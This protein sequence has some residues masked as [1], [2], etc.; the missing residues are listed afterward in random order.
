MLSSF[1]AKHFTTDR[2]FF[3]IRETGFASAA[4]VFPSFSAFHSCR[5]TFWQAEHQGAVAWLF[6]S[7]C[8]QWRKC[9]QGETYRWTIVDDALGF[10][11]QKP[12]SKMNMW[13]PQLIQKP[14][15]YLKIH[16]MNLVRWWFGNI[17]ETWRG[18][19]WKI[20]H[21]HHHASFTIANSSWNR[22]W[23]GGELPSGCSTTHLTLLLEHTKSISTNLEARRFP[24]RTNPYPMFPR[25]SFQISL[26]A[27]CDDLSGDT[28]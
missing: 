18:E 13:R 24:V 19:E 6:Y 7:C 28:V 22:G 26:P 10:A 3:S 9:F 12:P 20:A 8:R 5:C 25:K 4:P 1:K 27:V 17:E 15:Q 11:H 16:E 23:W 14:K 2:L 21:I